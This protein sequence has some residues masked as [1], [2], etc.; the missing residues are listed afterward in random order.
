MPSIS[1]YPS[2][3][4]P[5]ATSRAGVQNGRVLMFRDVSDVENAQREVQN[6]EKLLRT[7]IDHSVNGIIR[8]SWI[9]DDGSHDNRELRCGLVWQHRMG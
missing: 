9:S 6:S 8:M 2:A 3:V 5:I 7:L 4:T 1:R